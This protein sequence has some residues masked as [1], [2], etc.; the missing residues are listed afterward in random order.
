MPLAYLSAGAGVAVLGRVHVCRRVCAAAVH[1][2]M[3]AVTGSADA[4]TQEAAG[5]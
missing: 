1:G 3:E 2:D 5:G 4:T